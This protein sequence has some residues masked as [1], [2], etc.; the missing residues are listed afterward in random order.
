MK[1]S[2]VTFEIGEDAYQRRTTLTS[3]RDDGGI[4]I[5]LSADNIRKAFEAINV[6]KK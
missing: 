6:Y 4:I 2:I 1:P 5:D 3:Q